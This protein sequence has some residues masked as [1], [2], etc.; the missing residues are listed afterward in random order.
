MPQKI[1]LTIS[2]PAFNEEKTI[3]DVV[4]EVKASASKITDRYEILLI[5]DGSGDNTEN[6]MDRLSKTD[7]K[8]RVVHHNKNKGFTG[9]M[10]S[11]LYLAK[12]N[13]VF[14]APADGQF[15]FRELSKFV[16]AIQSYDVAVGYRINKYKNIPRK[17]YTWGFH[18]LSKT[19]F[20]IPFKE[21]SSVFL[22]RKKV[23]ESIKIESDDRSAIFLTEFFYKAVKE[24]YKFVEVPIMWRKRQGGKA[25]GASPLMIFKTFWAMAKFWLKIHFGK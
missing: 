6:M 19:L 18:F 3:L 21:F 10:K 13:L 9:A 12:N 15:D 20:S 5:D 8:V 23:I 4:K 17:I 16:D 7:S 11:A 25:K 24:R 22:C 14:L 1:S 2:I